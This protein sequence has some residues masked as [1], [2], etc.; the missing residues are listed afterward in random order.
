M[1]KLKKKLEA[2]AVEFVRPEVDEEPSR[3]SVL[4]PVEPNLGPDDAQLSF[5]LERPKPRLR[6]VRRHP[7][8]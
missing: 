3:S 6:A 2:Y 5:E 7:A 1:L 8:I 4:E